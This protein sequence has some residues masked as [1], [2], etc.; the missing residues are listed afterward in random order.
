MRPTKADHYKHNHQAH[1]S[2]PVC[3][4]LQNAQADAVPSALQP[5]FQFRYRRHPAL[6]VLH[7]LTVQV[8]KGRERYPLAG[9]GAAPATTRA[10]GAAQGS[11]QD[12]RWC[13]RAAHS[14]AG[15]ACGGLREARPLASCR[16]HTTSHGKSAA[17]TSDRTDRMRI[18]SMSIPQLLACQRRT[19]SFRSH[20]MQQFAAAARQQSRPP[21]ALAPLYG[22]GSC[23]NAASPQRRRRTTPAAAAAA[24]TPSLSRRGP[25]A[26]TSTAVAAARQVSSVHVSPAHSPTGNIASGSDEQQ[27]R[28]ALSISR[29]LSS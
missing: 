24:A 18:A 19:M 8:G 4:Q 11:V 26:G 23:S 5:T 16:R 2:R 7:Q 12:G 28:T 3:E 25:S 21:L 1:L 10:G 14:Q 6:M 9:A 29:S 20:L 27:G 13:L 17:C 22:D 15:C